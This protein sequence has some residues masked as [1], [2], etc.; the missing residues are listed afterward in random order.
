MNWPAALAD[1]GPGAPCRAGGALPGS[2]NGPDFERPGARR[3]PPASRFPA[4]PGKWTVRVR[5]APPYRRP[6]VSRSAGAHADCTTYLPGAF[7]GASRADPAHRVDSARLVAK[8]D[9]L[10]ELLLRLRR[11]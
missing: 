4:D 2:A 6:A 7:R 8:K 9:R 11:W 3:A 1:L 10:I 5:K